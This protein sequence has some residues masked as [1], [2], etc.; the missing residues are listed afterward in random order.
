M[1][2]KR[3]SAIVLTLVGLILGCMTGQAS[4][5]VIGFDFGSSFFKI[6][7]VQPGNPF[8][9]VE[10]TTTK[11]KT[12]SQF[13]LTKDVRWFGKD[14]FIGSTRFPKTTFSDLAGLFAVPYSQETVE[15]LA[16]EKFILY[17]FVEDDRGLIA[18]QTFSIDKKELKDDEDAKT[19][20]FTEELVGMI[21]SYGKGLSEF[22]ASG[23]SR[24]DDAV[25]T[26]PSYYNQE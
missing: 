14:S 24:V 3:N 21:L 9:I 22:Q 1:Q 6:T 13:T 16:L 23:N 11:R 5:N 25:I 12:E 19:T 15:K 7:L 20:Y 10:N 26:V 4:A 8:Q 2:L 18:V 17:D